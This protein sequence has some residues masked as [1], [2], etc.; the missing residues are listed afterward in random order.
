MQ[1]LSPLIVCAALLFGSISSPQ[2]SEPLYISEDLSMV[3]HAEQ[4]WG[5]LGINVAAHQSE[6]PGQPL[7]IGSKTYARGLGHHA[8]GR[9]DFS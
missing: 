4:G 9:V 5:V 3:V 2:A 7:R 1:R 6:I 8:N